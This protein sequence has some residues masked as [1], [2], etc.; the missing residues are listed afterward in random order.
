MEHLP[1]HRESQLVGIAKICVATD[2]KVFDNILY[3]LRRFKNI[4]EENRR[5]HND[6]T[7]YNIL[8]RK[9]KT[10]E[11]NIRGTQNTAPSANVALMLR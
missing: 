9:M 7:E 6:I 2:L 10:Q 1:L 4:Y 5:L 8:V 3:T 11:H